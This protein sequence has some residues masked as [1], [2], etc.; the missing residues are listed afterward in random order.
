ME[1]RG[2]KEEERM[3]DQV[4]IFMS[5]VLLSSFFLF[6]KHALKERRKKE[7]KEMENVKGRSGVD[8]VDQ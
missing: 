5:L 1:G 2:K 7:R 6:L 3:K 8:G 4:G